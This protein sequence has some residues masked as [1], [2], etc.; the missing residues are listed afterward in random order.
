MLSVIGKL[1]NWESDSGSS[2][3]REEDI[4]GVPFA[5]G[6]SFS[7]DGRMEYIDE[8]YDPPVRMKT[9]CEYVIQKYPFIL[10]TY[11]PNK[12]GCIHFLLEFKFPDQEVG[13]YLLGMSSQNLSQ[14]LQVIDDD[15]FSKDGYQWKIILQD[16]LPEDAHV[17]NHSIFMNDFMYY[18]FG[19]GFI[20]DL[21]PPIKFD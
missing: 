11:R 5:E 7:E 1:F 17:Y 6:F 20:H 16:E 15:N 2:S 21:V 18:Y 3:V 14:F 4:C 8:S 12:D 19:F 10:K 9:D 13:Y